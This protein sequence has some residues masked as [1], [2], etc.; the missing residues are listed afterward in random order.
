MPLNIVRGKVHTS[1]LPLGSENA[2]ELFLEKNES[3]TQ[4]FTVI[5]TIDV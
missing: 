2:L 3:K 1:D 5:A 4:L